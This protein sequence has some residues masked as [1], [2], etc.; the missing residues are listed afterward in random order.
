[1]FTFIFI[2]QTRGSLWALSIIIESP[3]FDSGEHNSSFD[4]PKT[5][6]E[7][8]I[9]KQPDSERSEIYYMH[10]SYSV[11]FSQI[12]KTAMKVINSD[13][14]YNEVLADCESPS[15]TANHE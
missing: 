2:F 13:F 15:L 12:E 14:P 4:G 3:S 8:S 7:H 11:A 9:I 10:E 1:M 6:I 5:F